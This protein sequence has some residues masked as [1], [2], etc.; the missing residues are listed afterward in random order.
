METEV[1]D[2]LH[3]LVPVVR[4][5][6]QSIVA[7]P[8]DTAVSRPAVL[9]SECKARDVRTAFTTSLADTARAGRLAELGR[10]VQ[11][12]DAVRLVFSEETVRRLTSGEL[13]IPIDKATG[14]PRAEARDSAGRIREGAR[15]ESMGRGR[16]LLRGVV[17]AAHVVSALDI[18]AQ[19][20]RLD[21]KLDHLV[22]LL[23]ADRVG[24]LRG[25]YL[26]L[27]KGLTEPDPVTRRTRLLGVSARLD[28]LQSRFL[29]T[30]R[31]ELT[32]IRNPK[33]ISRFQAIFSLQSSAE[34]ALRAGVGRALGDFRLHHLC[35]VLGALLHA[36]LDE[37]EALATHARALA[38]GIESAATLLAEKVGYFDS[39]AAQAAL[40]TATSIQAVR[41]SLGDRLDLLRGEVALIDG[42]V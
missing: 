10:V 7:T 32:A 24:E 9:L 17:A 29:E 41:G 39:E 8:F 5:L 31:A 19:L 27:Q 12:R 1:P 21:A 30:A 34:G 26:S 25:V 40:L 11:D 13:K 6:V 20:E 2:T 3:D 36:E 35:S 28:D 14:L 16:R 37:P 38:A 4:D 42:V 33:D 18:Q 23:Q 22:T 15:F